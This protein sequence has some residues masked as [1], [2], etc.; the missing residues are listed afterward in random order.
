MLAFTNVY[1]FESGLFN[2]LQPI[3][4]KK[5]WLLF[6]GC[7]TRAQGCRN[8]LWTARSSSA[9][10]ERD[11][12]P[13][14]PNEYHRFRLMAR[15][16]L[17]RFR[18]SRSPLAPS[19]ARLLGRAA[20][21]GIVIANSEAS[22]D[23]GGRGAAL[24]SPELLRFTGFANP[25]SRGNLRAGNSANESQDRERK[26]PRREGPTRGDAA[27]LGLGGKS[28]RA[29]HWKQSQLTIVPPPNRNL[30]PA[31]YLPKSR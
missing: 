11:L 22:G 18:H 27:R 13:T 28:K 9:A 25:R 24:R 21:D 30:L 6:P 20:L 26:T 7:A 16:C 19:V 15:F 31:E 4:I 2:G 8:W 29:E 12:D 23:P 5:P 3:G 10:R 1:F 14:I 17:E